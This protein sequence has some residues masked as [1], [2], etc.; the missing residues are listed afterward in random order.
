MR[1]KIDIEVKA[2]MFVAFGLL[3]FM[4]TVL[5]MGGAST[6]FR[7]D[8]AVFLEVHDTAGLAKGATIRSGGLRIGRV[9]EIDFSQGFDKVRITLLI[10][11]KY[12]ERIREDSL[13]RFQTQ[14]V[15]GDKFIDISPGS[16]E[17]AVIA[18]G[19][20]IQAELS[21]DLSAILADGTSAVELLKENLANLK[22]ITSSLAQKNQMSIIM[23]DLQSTTANLKDFTQA[24]KT[25][26]ASQELGSTLKNL[27]IVSE[28]VKNGEG[29]VGA[30]FNDSSL[31]EDLKHLVGGANRNNVLKFFVRQAVK[32][33]DDASLEKTEQGKSETPTPAKSPGK[34]PAST[35]R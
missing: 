5:A 4:V 2:G 25:S 11:E 19:G 3:C 12:K 18:P 22:I 31:Y 34:E 32:S 33:S 1:R 27:R 17:K 8:Y 9:S 16:A 35:N 29:T 14:G 24:L 23:R 6:L 28:R 13:V 10:E 26:N 7:K 15:L 30:L 20:S 21:K